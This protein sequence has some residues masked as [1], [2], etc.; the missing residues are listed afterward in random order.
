MLPRKGRP[1]SE[2]IIHYLSASL[3]CKVGTGLK[4]V[5]SF[6]WG[7]GFI[8]V[9]LE[10]E[11]LLVKAAN[12]T[13]GFSE[14]SVFVEGLYEGIREYEE[15]P[16]SQGKNLYVVLAFPLKGF[17]QGR[18]VVYQRTI[19]THCGR[20]GL[21]YTVLD[22]VGEYLTV[23]PPPGSLYDYTVISKNKIYLY[24]LK[25]RRIYEMR[26]DNVVRLILL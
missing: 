8:I 3:L 6:K 26:E 1:E 14:R 5:R 22:S 17:P 16:K 2:I 7:E 21:S 25:R 19:D 18:G 12:S 20:F 11:D 23:Y 10:D 24:L 9:S 13:I 4:C 15:S